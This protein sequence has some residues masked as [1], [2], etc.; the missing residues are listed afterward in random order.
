[1]SRYDDARESARKALDRLDQFKQQGIDDYRVSAG[2]VK[3][4]GILG[5]RQMIAEM[6]NHVR[7]TK[8]ADAVEDFKFEYQFA[9]AYAYAGMNA[10]CIEILESLLSDKSEIS[11][12]WLEH[13]PA[14]N[15]IRNT[16]EFIALLE[17]HR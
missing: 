7:S 15:G 2:A 10:E 4:H 3:A 11:V 12:P 9:Q 17:K 1:M 5:N 6:V 13:D 8:P 16:P 14:F